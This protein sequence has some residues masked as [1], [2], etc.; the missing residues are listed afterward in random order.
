MKMTEEKAAVLLEFSN[1]EDELTRGFGDVCDALGVEPQGEDVV[2]L[3][4]ALME[5][6]KAAAAELGCEP[7]LDAIL[8]AMKE[9]KAP[10]ELE[11]SKLS[12]RE[13]ELCR[14]SGIDPRKYA[15]TKARVKLG[16]R[17]A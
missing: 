3:A 14:K 7:K 17:R 4:G 12:P 9:Q 11:V 13:R 10:L 2:S 15:A 8:A 5:W 16:A 1:H 6:G